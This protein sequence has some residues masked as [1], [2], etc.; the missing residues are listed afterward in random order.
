MNTLSLVGQSLSAIKEVGLDAKTTAMLLESVGG[1]DFEQAI[2][3]A[4]SLSG[5]G[6]QASDDDTQDDQQDDSTN[7]SNAE[8]DEDF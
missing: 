3:I 7:K 6:G 2:A 5:G 4:K 1:F 8:E